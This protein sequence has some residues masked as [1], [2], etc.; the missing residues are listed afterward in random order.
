[1]LTRTGAFLALSADSFAQCRQLAQGSYKIS[2]APVRVRRTCG[3]KVVQVMQGGGY[4]LHVDNYKIHSMASAIAQKF[5]G[6]D[7][8]SN[9]STV[10]IKR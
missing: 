9:G 1:M 5:L 3:Q 4:S 2:C 8:K 10:S 6:A 7:L